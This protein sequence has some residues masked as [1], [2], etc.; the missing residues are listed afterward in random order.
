MAEDAFW[1][2]AG[3]SRGVNQPPGVTDVADVAGNPASS[4][5]GASSAFDTT[6]N[7]NNT[8]QELLQKVG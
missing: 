6:F 3:V 7:Y 2:E 8:L 4:S 1:H 5:S